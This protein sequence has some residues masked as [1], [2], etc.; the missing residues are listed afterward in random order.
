[1]STV[2]KENTIYGRLTPKNTAELKP[3]DTVHVDLIGTYSKSMRQ[4]HTGGAII[5]N[6]VSITCMTMINRATG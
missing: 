6:N 4:Q 1:M 2:K 5:N 3:F